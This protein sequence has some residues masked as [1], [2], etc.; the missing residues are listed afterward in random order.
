MDEN[1][2]KFT[3]NKMTKKLDEIM[4]QHLKDV[5]QQVGLKLPKLKKINKDLKQLPNIILPKLKKVTDEV[6]V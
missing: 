2:E 3:L 4:E 5:P 6:T 1:R